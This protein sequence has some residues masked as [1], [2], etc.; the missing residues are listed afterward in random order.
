MIPSRWRRALVGG[1]VVLGVSCG[2]A[3]TTL[4]DPPEGFTSPRPTSTT[5]Q[6]PPTAGDVLSVS[7]PA[8][9]SGGVLPAAYTCEGSDRS[10]P[11]Q[12]TAVPEGTVELAVVVTSFA[13]EQSVNWI[14]TGIPPG[15]TGL[16]EGS[17]PPAV[18]EGPN[19]T[20]GTGWSGP[21]PGASETVQVNVT[22]YALP[23]QV[24][25]TGVA[26]PLELVARLDAAG[27][28]RA[29]MTAQFT[30]S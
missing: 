22:L 19:S 30:G 5:S 20:G 25:P 26:D 13:A 11:L 16:A 2:S 6:P 15:Q 27:G 24:D 10:P 23:A 4:R 8:V 3:G 29:A 28:S 17:V 7:S 12:W 21:C 1:L 18:T 14:V 9:V